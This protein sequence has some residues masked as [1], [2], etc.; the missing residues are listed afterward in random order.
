MSWL[1]EREEFTNDMIPEGA[2]GFVYGMSVLIDGETKLY[3]GKKNFYANRNVKL[4]KKA[5]DARTDK[6]ASKKKLVRKLSYQNYFSSNE[7]L[8]QAKKDGLDIRRVIM[9]ICYSKMELTYEEVACMF[10]LD[11]LDNTQYLNTNI[12]GKFYRGKIRKNE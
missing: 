2:H 9:K 5:L 6:R 11:V 10:K 3:I 12:L 8:K 4:G 1:Y 7:T